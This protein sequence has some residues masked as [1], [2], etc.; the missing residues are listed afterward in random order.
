MSGA[1]EY[2]SGKSWS[3]MCRGSESRANTSA[4]LRWQHRIPELGSRIPDPGSRNLKPEIRIQNLKTENRNHG[5]LLRW[6]TRIP[7]PET[8]NPD[9]E[10][11]IPEPETRNPGSSQMYST[12]YSTAR[13]HSCP[14]AATNIKLP[15]ST[16][17][18]T[19]IGQLSQN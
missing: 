19:F 18:Q 5:K 14:G 3:G 12:A 4:H 9:P 17:N 7:T 15:P 2:F 1:W 11:R 6:Q 13:A 10:T 8:R 16:F